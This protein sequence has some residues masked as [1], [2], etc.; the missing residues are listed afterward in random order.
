MTRPEAR[1]TGAQGGI[2]VPYAGANRIRFDGCFSA[3]FE[4]PRPRAAPRAMAGPYSK[5]VP[6]ERPT[7]ERFPLTSAF[8][9]VRHPDRAGSSGATL[10]DP[11]ACLEEEVE[12][13]FGFA[14][15]VT[16]PIS[17]APRRSASASA[18]RRSRFPTP[19]PRLA[20]STAIAS[21]DD[22]VPRSLTIGKPT[23]R[24]SAQATSV[25]ASRRAP[26]RTACSPAAE[27][28]SPNA[29]CPS[30][31]QERFVARTLAEDRD[32]HERSSLEQA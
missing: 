24:S 16:S 21:S 15:A 17:V 12:R 13:A 32:F 22:A 1:K 5:S 27:S 31:P 29:R 18:A 9:A 4:P 7:R 20:S 25:S 14:A 2:A 3:T 10:L 6:S 19:A 28:Y 23:G 26:S 30:D 8:E 11:K